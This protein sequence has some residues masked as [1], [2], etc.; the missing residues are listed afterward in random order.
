MA[1][2][3][4]VRTRL[5]KALTALKADVVHAGIFDFAGIFR[6]RRLR[7]QELLAGADTAVF[8][9]VLPKWDIAETIMFPGPY[10]SEPIAYDPD[11][12]R[13]FPFEPKAAALVADYT[14]P[15]AEIMP[16]RIL[17]AQIEKAQQRGFDVRAAFE[18]EFIAL[19]ETAE[20]LRA[21]NFAGLGS[22]AP[23][24]RCWSGQTA[25][26]HAGF[27][28]DLEALLRSADID[29]FALGGELG[30]G[31]F[32]VTLRHQAPMRAADDAAFFRLYTKAFCRQRGMTASFMPL[33]GEGFPGIGGHIALSLRDRRSGRN[34]FADRRDANGLSAMA[35]SFL[36]GVIELAPE[37]FPMI[38]HT[39][40]AYRRLSPGS[41]AP[42]TASWAPY[43]YAAAVRTAAETHDMTRLELRLPGSDLNVH[44]GL[45][46]FLGAGL[47]GL[48]RKLALKDA[49][50]A[51]GGP[52]EIPENAPRLPA[53]L[54]EA[55]RRFRANARARRLFGAAFVDHFA[56]V[57][58]A[59]DAALRRAVSTAEVKRYLELG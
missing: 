8:A 54:L 18:F 2:R 53:D 25:A 28:A 42:K 31:C 51:G 10:G 22:F 19:N 37:A 59:E 38:A 34:L 14:G 48:D 24:N 49:P 6:E 43:N 5:A 36:A 12:L 32:E 33:L 47:D 26:V 27:V 29:L 20:S 3:N 23:D 15:Q 16:R 58:E 55:T 50:I 39:V 17:A 46:L 45:A 41:W 40:N 13:P 7:R 56:A 11:S 57:C 4:D 44:L 52:N 35:K 21:K 30:P 9:N 1:K